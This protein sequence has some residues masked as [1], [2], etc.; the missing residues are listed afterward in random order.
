MVYSFDVFDTC[1]TRRYAQPAD[2]FWEVGLVEASNEGIGESG[3]FAYHF[4]KARIRVEKKVRRRIR[5]KEFPSFDEIYSGGELQRFASLGSEKLKKAELE[6][7]FHSIYPIK[8]ILDRI[9]LLRDAGHRIIFV[10]DM[11]LSTSEIVSLLREHGFYQN[12][13]GVYVSSDVRLSKYSGNL[14]RRVLKEEGVKPEEVMHIGDNFFSDVERP[15]QLGM[16]TEHYSTAVLNGYERRIVGRKRP[17]RSL[18]R[19]LIAA[20]SRE[21]RL[22]LEGDGIEAQPYDG[23]VSAVLAP[24]LICYVQ[25]VLDQALQRGL[26]R[27]YFVARDGEVMHKIAQRLKRA[28]DNIQLRYLYGS[29]RAWHSAAFSY[30]DRAAWGRALM[31][32]SQIHTRARIFSRIGLNAVD[33]DRISERLG[34]TEDMLTA[35]LSR[36]EA[37]SFIDRLMAD[38]QIVQ[39][40]EKSSTEKRKLTLA[41]FKQEGLLDDV[42]WALVDIG[43]ALNCQA[44]LKR[45]LSMS[46]NAVRTPCGFYVALVRNRMEEKLAGPAFQ[47][48]GEPEAS[49]C[50]KR[51][52]MEHVI[53]PASHAST[54]GYRLDGEVVRPIL[55][56]EPRG[57]DELDYAERLHKICSLEAEVVSRNYD[58]ETFRNAYAAVISQCRDFLCS[59]LPEDVVVMPDMGAAADFFHDGEFIQTLCTKLTIR[60]FVKQ[61]RRIV[62]RKAR[63]AAPP[64]VWLEGSCAIS[65]W[66][67][68]LPLMGLLNGKLYGMQL[69]TRLRRRLGRY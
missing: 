60:D 37:Q 65:S 16:R 39:I 15:R 3:R 29:R 43:W 45:I 12:G 24:F 34:L 8:H 41:Y 51:T 59:P 64:E 30:E 20:L 21:T 69:T 11:Y 66:Y 32:D 36:D 23:I 35:F 46:K 57:G 19:S 31:P 53:T 2:V 28:D 7:E 10:S 58:Q 25:W 5:P 27:L 14:F 67:V 54:I 68:R 47:F 38:D 49:F 1:L 40:I 9:A 61:I 33:K 63:S 17:S 48:V 22:R 26:K 62:S 13:D 56:G 4:A 55:D 42:P 18:E 6:L 52:L 50:R 44:T